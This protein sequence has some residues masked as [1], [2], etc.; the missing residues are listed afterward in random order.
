MADEKPKEGQS[1]PIRWGPETGHL[2]PGAD[3]PAMYANQFQLLIGD[4][5]VRLAF[6]ETLWGEQTKMRVAIRMSLGTAK[7]LV[8]VLDRLI[9][10]HEPS[11]EPA[12]GQT[13]GT[14][15]Q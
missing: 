8:K 9:R 3:I 14:S 6:G 11:K 5:G 13:D 1:E 10:D 7:E 12:D 4:E 2:F 15:G